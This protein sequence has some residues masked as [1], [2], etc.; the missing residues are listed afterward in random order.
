MHAA[1]LTLVASTGV[2]LACW[3]NGLTVLLEKVFGNIYIDKMWAICLLEANYN[4]LNKFVFAKQ[5]MDKAF[6]GVII[7]VEQFEKRGSQATEGVLISGLFCDIAR[8]LH[9]TVA[10]ESVDLTNCY[11]AVAHPNASIALQHFKVCKV[12]VAM[13]YMCSKP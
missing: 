10:I 6:Q 1:K 7:P 12:M 13:S 5:M 9:K 3:G 8:A 11:D 2:P 4:W